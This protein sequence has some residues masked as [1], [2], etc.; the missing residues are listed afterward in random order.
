MEYLEEVVSVRALPSAQAVM[1]G[2]DR[3]HAQLWANK[4]VASPPHMRFNLDRVVHDFI[5]GVY[6]F[7]FA[8][9]FPQIFIYTPVLVKTRITVHYEQ[10]C[11]LM[12]NYDVP[13]LRLVWPAVRR[14]ML[15]VSTRS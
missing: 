5:T 3:G 1:D 4:V 15:S 9:F 7:H 2:L 8:H 12:A 6:I 14:V 10:C 13:K 11:R